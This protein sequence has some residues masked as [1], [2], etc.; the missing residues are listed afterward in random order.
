M[1]SIPWMDV[2]AERCYSYKDDWQFYDTQVAS[3]EFEKNKMIT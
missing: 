1:S 3:F 2:G